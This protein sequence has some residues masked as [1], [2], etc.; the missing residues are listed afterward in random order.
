MCKFRP[1][2]KKLIDEKLIQKRGKRGK[3]KALTFE[4][5]SADEQIPNKTA[6]N[7][8]LAGKIENKEANKNGEKIPESFEPSLLTNDDAPPEDE[9]I[10]DSLEEIYI[11]SK[12]NLKDLDLS[13]NDLPAK[14]LWGILTLKLREKNYVTLHTACGEIREVLREGNL[15]KAVVYEEYLMNILTKQENFD[16]ILFELRQIDDKI[17]LE[18]ELKRVGKNKSKN[19][20]QLLKN[21]FG[22]LGVE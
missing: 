4:K 18:F 7:E 5:K 3:E 11:K 20:M 1:F 2:K 9:R 12:V 21:L 19:N 10:E 13:Q 14:K 17:S 22:D 8:N 15:I 16:K 6:S